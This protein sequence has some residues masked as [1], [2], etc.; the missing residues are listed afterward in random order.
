M[1]V[2][3]TGGAG[4]VGSIVVER[5]LSSVDSVV[6]VDNLQQ[7]HAKAVLPEAT[8]IVADICDSDALEDVFRRFEIDTVMHLAAEALVEE[9]MTEPRKFFRNNVVGGM[10]LVDTMLR[11]GVNR[12]VFSSTGAVYGEP[13]SIPIDE[14]HPKSPVNSYGESKLVF[15]RVL[16]WYARAYGLRYVCLRYF[17]AAGASER[18]GEDHCPET[19]L[20]PIILKT[21]LNR[22]RSIDLFG[23]DYPTKDGSCVRDYVHVLDVAEAHILALDKVEELSGSAF[24]LGNGSG[25][26]V[27]EVIEL[28]KLITGTDI[29]AQISARRPGDPAVLIASSRRARSQLGWQPAFS[30]LTDMIESSWRWM[31]RNPNGYGR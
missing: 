16:Q 13:L 25:Y 29:P 15:E 3:C 26:S 31:K 19:H 2:L 12:I 30:D 8:L 28:A 11:H 14:D 24:N 21:A 7:G 9:S 22:D 27:S 6:V 1:N 18:F 4:Y 23:V 20:I 10:N 5:L 17:N